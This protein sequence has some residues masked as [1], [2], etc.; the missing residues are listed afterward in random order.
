MKIIIKKVSDESFKKDRQ[1]TLSHG[2]TIKAL[3]VLISSRGAKLQTEDGGYDEG[4]HVQYGM[5][6]AI[7]EISKGLNEIRDKVLMSKKL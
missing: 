2:D 5:L 3:K 1:I 7:D 6:D 4:P